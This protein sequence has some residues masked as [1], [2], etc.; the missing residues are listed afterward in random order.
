MTSD[1]SVFGFSKLVALNASS[2]PVESPTAILKVNV[3]LNYFFC[4]F[5]AGSTFLRA[6]LRLNSRS[7]AFCRN[8]HPTS[9]PFQWDKCQGTSSGSSLKRASVRYTGKYLCSLLSGE[10]NWAT[11]TLTRSWSIGNSKFYAERD[12]K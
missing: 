6:G 7:T 1:L 2:V 8:S 12:V 3:H 4:V 9:G 10:K 5:L 11:S